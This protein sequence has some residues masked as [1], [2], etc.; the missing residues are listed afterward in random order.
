MLEERTVCTTQPALN[1]LILGHTSLLVSVAIKE[2]VYW[3][4]LNQDLAAWPVGF[5]MWNLQQGEAASALL[6]T[7][8]SKKSWVGHPWVSCWQID[9]WWPFL[10]IQFLG[11][12][13]GILSEQQ[14]IWLCVSGWSLALH[15]LPFICL[16][17]AQ[18]CPTFPY[19]HVHNL[20]SIV[21]SRN[22]NMLMLAIG[23][24]KNPGLRGVAYEK[25]K[26]NVGWAWIQKK[27]LRGIL[28]S[29]AS[30]RLDYSQMQVCKIGFNCLL[31]AS[32]LMPTLP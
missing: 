30:E 17:L 2:P 14:S 28:Q 3:S 27:K 8:R 13:S 11:Q 15:S 9:C 23:G 7:S 16:K 18:C 20:V 6:F 25:L 5:C 10:N 24:L 12:V 22:T 29:S 1:I 31:T 19:S 21:N 32:W 26:Q 4:R